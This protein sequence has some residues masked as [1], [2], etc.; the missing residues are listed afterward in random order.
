VR[1]PGLPTVP[2]TIAAEV[3]VAP[4]KQLSN[5][6]A[7]PEGENFLNEINRAGAGSTA[8]AGEFCR[9]EIAGRQELPAGT[10][11]AKV[12]GAASG[13]QPPRV[14]MRFAAQQNS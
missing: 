9:G 5:R 13:G 2:S 6:Y 10:G 3:A 11:A 4:A 1:F 14:E 8:P 7:T 12:R